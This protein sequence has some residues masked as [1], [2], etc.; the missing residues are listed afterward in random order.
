MMC[1]TCGRKKGCPTRK[2]G[3]VVGCHRPAE[4]ELG[5]RGLDWM[6][7]KFMPY[8]GVEDGCYGNGAQESGKP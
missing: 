5:L 2:L 4:D 7:A 8:A 3:R 6:P 1:R